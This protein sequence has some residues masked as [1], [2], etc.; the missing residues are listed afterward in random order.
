MDNMT[1]DNLLDEYFF[2]K[3]LRP[4]TESSYRKVM[5]TFLVFAGVESACSSDPT[6]GP[7]VAQICVAPVWTERGDLE[8]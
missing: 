7:G 4:D 1:W 5:N 6:T 3:I 8:Q 2:A